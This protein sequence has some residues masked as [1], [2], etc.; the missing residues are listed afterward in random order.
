MGG[1]DGE[2]SDLQKE[3]RGLFCLFVVILSITLKATFFSH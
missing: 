3:K 1:N 2:E